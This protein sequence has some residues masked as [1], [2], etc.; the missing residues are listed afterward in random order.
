MSELK[1]EAEREEVSP[2]AGRALFW[3]GELA[4]RERESW[5]VGELKCWSSGRGVTGN[6]PA[7]IRRCLPTSPEE[8]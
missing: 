8:P 7:E 1:L 6:G 5:V 2:R 3:A 4:D